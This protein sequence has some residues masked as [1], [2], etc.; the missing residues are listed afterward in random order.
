[1]WWTKMSA[2]FDGPTGPKS[3]MPPLAFHHSGPEGATLPLA[4]SAQRP[5]APR[6]IATGITDVATKTYRRG[7]NTSW[8]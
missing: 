1:M 6:V 4:Q 8:R 5:S 2:Q 7:G 3:S